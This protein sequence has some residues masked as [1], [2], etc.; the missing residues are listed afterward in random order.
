MAGRKSLRQVAAVSV[1]IYSR[2]YDFDPVAQVAGVSPVT[3]QSW[4]ARHDIPL[5]AETLHPGR[6]R[7]RQFRYLDVVVIC[8]IAE[9]QRVGI[10]LESASHIANWVA[11]ADRSLARLKRP[12]RVKHEPLD[13]YRGGRKILAFTLELSSTAIGPTVTACDPTANIEELRASFTKRFHE[14]GNTP[15]PKSITFFNL[16]EVIR[17]TDRALEQILACEGLND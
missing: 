2:Q 9:F 4:L 7:V 5:E 16:G 10:G 3:M 17:R 11:G 12:A 15:P 14:D 1:G 13:S 8:L 6:G